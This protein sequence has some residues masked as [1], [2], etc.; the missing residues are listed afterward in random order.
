MF[1]AGVIGRGN[2]KNNCSLMFQPCVTT[3]DC[4]STLQMCY[5]RKKMSIDFFTSLNSKLWIVH[6]RKNILIFFIGPNNSICLAPSDPSGQSPT[7]FPAPGAA[8]NTPPSNP[9]CGFANVTCNE[10]K[11]CCAKL[12][13]NHSK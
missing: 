13:C 1:S 4:C 2:G 3:Q 6:R 10:D 8:K 5:Q 12:I 11:N 7:R 9:G